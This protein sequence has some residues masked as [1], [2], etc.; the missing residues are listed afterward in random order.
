VAERYPNIVLDTSAIPYPRAIKEAVERI[1]STRVLYASDGPGCDPRIEV[2]KVRLA[3]L[4][5]QDEDAV[6]HRSIQAILDRV[7]VG[8]DGR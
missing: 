2:H 1:G 7:S 8:G 3:G 5:A 4:T 6:F